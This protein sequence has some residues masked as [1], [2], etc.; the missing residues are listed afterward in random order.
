[1]QG[2]SKTYGGIGG[3]FASL[4][5]TLPVA[6]GALVAGVNTITFRFNVGNG[7]SIGYRIV[8]LNL[9]DSAGK[10]LLPA[11]LFQRDEPATWL[12]PAATTAQDVAIG[13]SLW[14]SA[15]LKANAEPNA[16]NIIARCG[17]CHTQNG[18][19]LKYFG[20]SNK[21]IIERAKFHGLTQAQGNQIAAYI[22]ALP[23]KAVGRPWN[24]PYQPGANTSSKPNDE[25]A[26]GAGL[27]NVLDE[28]WDTIKAIFPDGIKRDALMVGDTNKFKRFSSHDTPIAFQLPDWNHWLPEV[29]PYDAYGKAAVDGTDNFK[30][31]KEIR[32]SLLG[33]SNAEIKEWFRNSFPRQSNAAPKGY[34]ALLN[35]GKHF[36]SEI[37]E[38]GWAGVLNGDNRI[39]TADTANAKKIYSAQLWKMV[40]LF[41]IHDEFGLTSMGN[42]PSNVA[43]ANFDNKAVLPRMWIGAERVVF[44]VSPFLSYL[45]DGITG[46]TSGNNAFNYDYLSNAWYQ[47]QLILNAGQRTGHGHQVVDWGY[48]YG[49]LDGMS[50]KTDFNQAGRNI[51]WSLKG[52]DE[53]DNDREPNTPQG[54]SFRRASMDGPLGFESERGYRVPSRLWI[55]QPSAEAKSVSTLFRQVWLEKNASWLPEQI[56]KYPDG[57]PKSGDEDGG[58]FNRPDYVV[59]SAQGNEAEERSFAEG[60]DR[61]MKLYILYKTYPAALQNGYAAWAQAVWPGTDAQGLPRNNWL[62]YSV[63]RVGSAPATPSVA[64]GATP[65]SVNVTWAQGAGVRS[66]NVKRADSPNGPFL[67]VAYFRTGISYVDTA[68]LLGRTYYYRVSANVG[69][70]ASPDETPDSGSVAI[71][72]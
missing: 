57:T 58:I 28:D 43:W 2:T 37:T 16:A 9:L 54:W 12:A 26:A 1:M 66:Y 32:Q 30:M 61:M 64:S 18:A 72:R 13:Q 41:E 52:M 27:D 39:Q 40:K 31:Y 6:A 33:K 17:D 3:S 67:T 25:W 19:D 51:V 44:D 55:T 14:S 68:P 11:N 34:F 60:T 15:S 36:P 69:L 48:A 38:K 5:M 35:F 62:R 53:G 23:V 46:S 50:R 42:E 70:S 20:Y 65:A 8:N 21:A 22:R 56:A 45:M 63:A 10:T 71:A 59:G 47:L 49:F 7:L 24:P 4:K 29:H